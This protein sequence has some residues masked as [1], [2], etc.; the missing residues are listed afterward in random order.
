M[1]SLQADALKECVEIVC[2]CK[3][4]EWWK[5]LYFMVQHILCLLWQL[6]LLRFYMLLIQWPEF[7]LLIY[8]FFLS[9]A[10]YF[11]KIGSL[12]LWWF[13]HNFL[14]WCCSFVNPELHVTRISNP[15]IC[16]VCSSFL[17]S[18]MPTQH[19][20]EHVRWGWH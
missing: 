3:D 5:K 15:H 12:I 13:I 9:Y 4:D 17:P 1:H 14:Q 19:P 10:P 2:E 20:C 18:V 8:D 16:T 7:F 6:A 11:R